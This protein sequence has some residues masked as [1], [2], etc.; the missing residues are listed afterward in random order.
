M[1]CYFQLFPEK[2]QSELRNATFFDG[3]PGEAI[4]RGVY[5]FTEFFCADPKC[6]C[7]RVL[8]KVLRSEL[9]GTDPEDVATISYS[10]ATKSNREWYR[11]I[12]E[13]GNPVLDPLHPQASYAQDLL[14]FWT[15]MIRHDAAY[16]E[17]IKRHYHELRAAYADSPGKQQFAAITGGTRTMTKQ[18]R[19][20][21]QRKLG[22]QR[23]Q[24]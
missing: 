24:R 19:R 15:E 3:E 18:Q 12:A 6:N 10:W 2:A 8:I 11:L 5:A 16:L 17:R 13:M 21:R 23:A 1:R 20:A 7:Q 4:P 9:A 14:E 22:S